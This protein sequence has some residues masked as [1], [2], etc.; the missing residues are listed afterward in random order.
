VIR[1]FK[2]LLRPTHRQEIALSVMLADHCR[3]YNAALQ[4]RRDAYAHPSKTRIKYGDQS[5]Q[6]KEIRQTD[7]EGQGRWSFSSQQATLR[8]L[9]KAFAA[10]FRRLKAGEKPGYP[11][12][13]SVA[14]FDTVEFPKDG[15]GCRWDSAPHLAD[16][17][18]RLQGI[19]HVRVHQH[20]KVTGRVKTIQ[21]KREGDRWYVILACDQVPAE[22]L[23]A[24]GAVVGIDMGV[25]SFLTTSDG[26]HVPN[27]RYG[28]AAAEELA[29]AQQELDAFPQRKA[30]KR[31]KKHQRAVVKVSN[32]Y[33]KVA[34]Q[35]LD[36]AH[37]TAMALVRDH[38]VIAHENLSVANMVKAPKAKPNPDLQGEFLPNGAAA[39]AGLNRS[40]SDAGWGVFLGILAHKAEWAGRVV[41]PVNPRNTSRTCPECGHVAKENRTT[42]AQFRCVRCAFTAHADVVG[43]TNVLRA[44][45]ALYDTA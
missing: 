33:R 16:T 13:R 27:P 5:A 20:R 9:N 39:K 18:V 31:T 45:L 42:Q 12:F 24:T 36:H 43:A 28:K 2:F 37:K 1:S 25:A 8:R 7:P 10:F 32:L 38:D 29:E 30:R 41:I 14:R 4:E 35:R 11:R 22:T 44:G 6:L 26:K 40:I 3:M 17:R 34:R 15:D 23:P 19:G 21:V